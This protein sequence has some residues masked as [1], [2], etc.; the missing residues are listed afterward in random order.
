M[1]FHIFDFNINMHHDG[2][3]KVDM[4]LDFLLNL[5]SCLST[6]FAILILIWAFHWENRVDFEKQSIIAGNR[7]LMYIFQSFLS[8]MKKE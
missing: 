4:N 3:F 2:S 7:A 6:A 5:M 8:K 1:H